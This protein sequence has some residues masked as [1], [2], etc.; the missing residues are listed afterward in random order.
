MVGRRRF[1]DR[2]AV[3]VARD[4]LG[5]SLSIGGCNVVITE[6]E[7][8][9]ADDPASHSFRGK[10]ARN[11]SM[12]A[13]PGTAYVYLS[14]GVHW[15]VNIACGPVGVGEAVLVRGGA[16]CAGVEIMRPRRPKARTV[17][18]LTVGPGRLTQAL[19]IDRS[20]DGADLLADEGVI[21]IRPRF[22]VPDDAVTTTRRI[23]LSKAVDRPWR[24]VALMPVEVFPS[25]PA[26]GADNG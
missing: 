10:T 25:F 24:F 7:A 23:G 21:L 1:F 9:T 2:S 13:A 11:A 18:E 22:L 3:D 5:W 20:V 26:V 16:P 4:V 19:G 6:T 12:F 17:A 15:C 14:Y 8:Y